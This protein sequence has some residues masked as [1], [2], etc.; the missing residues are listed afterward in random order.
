MLCLVVVLFRGPVA[1]F[2]ALSVG[3]LNSIMFPTIFTI[4]LERARISQAATSGL[5]CLAIVGGAILPYTVGRL[6]D[7]ASLSLA[8][9]VPLI[10]YFYITAF[11]LRARGINVFRA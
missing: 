3:L 9:G 1:G 4:T 8:F 11:A 6:A 5:L 2:A 10:A 7:F